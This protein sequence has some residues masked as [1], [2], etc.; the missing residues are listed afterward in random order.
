MHYKFS[1]VSVLERGQKSFTVL[2]KIYFEAKNTAL[3]HLAVCAT[4]DSNKIVH[5]DNVSEEY[6][7]YCEHTVRYDATLHLFIIVP[8]LCHNT[9]E[10][11]SDSFR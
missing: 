6:M 2:I 4:Q 8:V 5:Q 9:T 10:Q 7:E 3:A 11:S 1:V